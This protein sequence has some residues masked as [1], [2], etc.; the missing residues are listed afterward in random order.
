M[1]HNGLF[2]IIN[3]DAYDEEWPMMV[4]NSESWWQRTMTKHRRVK[5]STSWVP[6]TGEIRRHDG[7]LI[8]STRGDPVNKGRSMIGWDMLRSNISQQILSDQRVDG[9]SN[10]F[11]WNPTVIH[12][13]PIACVLTATPAI[14]SSN[15][16]IGWWDPQV[17]PKDSMALAVHL[18]PRGSNWA[19]TMMT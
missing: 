14:S 18:T 1:A 4:N 17:V 15:C 3:Y 19:T 5:S 12:C 11:W 10:W 6:R 13:I 8:L 16:P 9:W 2:T 7:W